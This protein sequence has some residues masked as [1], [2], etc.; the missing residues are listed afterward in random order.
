MNA[1][2]QFATGCVTQGRLDAL[3]KAAEVDLTMV[4]QALNY[5][6]SYTHHTDRRRSGHITPQQVR[7]VLKSRGS[8]EPND[9]AVT[10]GE[11]SEPRP[12]K[13]EGSRE[14]WPINMPYG[15]PRERAV[16]GLIL[17]IERGWFAYDRGGYLQWSQ[18]GRDRYAS[19]GAVIVD[20]RTGQSAFNF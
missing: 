3:A 17:G 10:P 7:A 9:P 20:S 8:G 12:C 14:H 6:L 1:L 13:P 18:A 5:G 11:F 2:W 4:C 15:H 16:W 19:G